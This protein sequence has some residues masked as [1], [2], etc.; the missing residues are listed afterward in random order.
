MY[1]ITFGLP[2]SIKPNQPQGNSV[3]DSAS[4]KKRKGRDEDAQA[5]AL[6]TEFKDESRLLWCHEINIER[7]PIKSLDSIYTYTFPHGPLQSAFPV[8]KNRANNQYF[9][10]STTHPIDSSSEGLKP[11]SSSLKEPDFSSGSNKK[12]RSLS[13]PIDNPFT[14][15]GISDAFFSI[16]CTSLLSPDLNSAKESKSAASS[17]SEQTNQLDWSINELKK[18]CNMEQSKK[19]D[20]IVDEILLDEQL[21]ALLTINGDQS[22][23]KKERLASVFEKMGCLYKIKPEKK[24]QIDAY[25][26]SLEDIMSGN[27]NTKREKIYFESKVRRG[28]VDEQKDLYQ[29]VLDFIQAVSEK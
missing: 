6:E 21:E 8:N 13:P 24:H 7:A 19:V 4:S 18:F 9:P 3:A 17:S 23:V 29:A 1:N 22:S 5:S 25:L 14:L 27:E 16:G 20:A 11:S 28:K 2:T 26:E 15:G 10:P 12:N